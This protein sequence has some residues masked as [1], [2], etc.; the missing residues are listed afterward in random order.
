MIFLFIELQK[1]WIGSI[2]L[3]NEGGYELILRALNH[4]KKR[5]RTI[6]SSPEIAD[7]PM[8][9]QIVLQEAMKTYP[10]INELIKKIPKALENQLLLVDLQNDVDLIAKSLISYEADIKKA[11]DSKNKYYLDLVKNP[12]NLS[13]DLKEITKA[14][15]KIKQFS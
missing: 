5:I 2:Y 8:F 15:E 9:K 7:A 11:L 10:K 4:Y 12:Q 13:G 1:T 14:I 3:K 6:E